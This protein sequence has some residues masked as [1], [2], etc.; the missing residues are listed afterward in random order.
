LI[1]G[2]YIV[3][4]QC[5]ASEATSTITVPIDANGFNCAPN[6][7]DSNGQLA[8]ALARSPSDNW[9]K[10]GDVVWLRDGSHYAPSAMSW[11]LRPRNDYNTGS[12]GYADNSRLAVRSRTID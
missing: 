4:V 6:S 10:L 9:I 5:A 1:D 8:T 12:G 3:V 2:P 11:Q 7:V